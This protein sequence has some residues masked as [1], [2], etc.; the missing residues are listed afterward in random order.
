[1]VIVDYTDSPKC[2]KCNSMSANVNSNCEEGKNGCPAVLHSHMEC[3]RC[4]FSWFMLVLGSPVHP[5]VDDL[6]CIKCGQADKFE[7]TFCEVIH[8]G[9]PS[10]PHHHLTCDKCKCF[11]FMESAE[12]DIERQFDDLDNF[13]DI[14]P[15]CRN[16]E[17][18]LKYIEDETD[19]RCKN[20]SN[21]HTELDIEGEHLHGRCE[22]CSFKWFSVTAD[23]TEEKP[24][25]QEE[26]KPAPEAKV[27]ESA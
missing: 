6:K 23:F 9:G 1:M 16:A 2:L 22:F 10:T 5:F 18:E 8:A 3:G 27:T 26:P 20:S 19:R 12:V 15:K 11:W 14:C 4:E 21:G 7:C 13:T 24:A 17:V 25:V